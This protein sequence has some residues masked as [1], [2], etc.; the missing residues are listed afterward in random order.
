MKELSIRNRVVKKAHDYI[1]DV[2]EVDHVEIDEVFKEGIGSYVGEGVDGRTVFVLTA[3]YPVMTLVANLP[4]P[5]N[6]GEYIACKGYSKLKAGDEWRASIG[7]DICCTRMARDFAN[8]VFSEVDTIV[9]GI[10]GE[11]RDLLGVSKKL[12]SLY[13]E[14]GDRALLA[15]R[16]TTRDELVADTFDAVFN[17][18]KEIY[19]RDYE[20]EEYDFTVGFDPIDL[21][22]DLTDFDLTDF[23]E[24]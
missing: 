5:N 21:D 4:D 6:K 24:D 7:L 10:E 20:P 18:A 13:L 12:A 23:E 8:Q 3:A 11:A 15:I 2:F 22:F 19:R 16:A 9:A 1:A 14:G 17:A